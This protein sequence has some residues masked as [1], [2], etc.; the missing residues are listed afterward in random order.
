MLKTNIYTCYFPKLDQKSTRHP[1]PSNDNR[2]H[3]TFLCLPQALQE[4]KYNSV[5]PVKKIITLAAVD[6]DK[7]L[8]TDV[9]HL[10]AA[11]YSRTSEFYF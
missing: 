7:D 3:H 4:V 8:L 1:P 6:R 2:S 9:N 10:A 11:A 5:L